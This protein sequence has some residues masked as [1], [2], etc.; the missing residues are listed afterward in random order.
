MILFPD[1][2]NFSSELNL[3]SSIFLQFIFLDPNLKNDFYK[4]GI[5][6]GFYFGREFT[7]INQ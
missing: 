5:E 2:L 4:P 1:F 7:K 6:P 3:L